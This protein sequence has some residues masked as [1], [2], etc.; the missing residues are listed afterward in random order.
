MSI[1][2]YRSLLQRINAVREDV[3][4]D[5]QTF[6]N[7]LQDALSIDSTQYKGGWNAASNTPN[8]SASSPASGDFYIVSKAGTT[9]LGGENKWLELDRVYY[10]GS[11]WQKLLSKSLPSGVTRYTYLSTNTSVTA[12]SDAGSS[13]PTGAS[14]G[15][16]YRNE[17]GRKV[18]WYLYGDTTQTEN[19]LGDFDGF[20]AVVDL[21][22]AQ[23]YLYWTLYTR[24]ELDGQDASWYRSRVT[25]NDEIAVQSASG[26]VLLHSAGMDV[27]TLHPDLPRVAVDIDAL[28]TNGLQG[29]TEVVWLMAL[30]T[31]S[32]YPEGYNEFVVEQAGFQFGENI[33]YCDLVAL[34]ESTTEY[35]DYYVGDFAGSSAFPSTGSVGQWLIETQEDK[36]FVWD[37]E[38]SDWVVT[39]AAAGPS[40]EGSPYTYVYDSIDGSGYGFVDATGFSNLPTGELQAESNAIGGSCT[41]NRVKIG[42]LV[43]V[44]DSV[45]LE[46]INWT[47]SP[48]YYRN[49]FCYIAKDHDVVWYQGYRDI[50]S[51]QGYYTESS[52]DPFAFGHNCMVKPYIGTSSYAGGMV[53]VGSSHAYPNSLNNFTLE[54]RL[55]ADFK[56]EMLVDGT[57][58]SRSE[59]SLS[60]NFVGGLDIWILAKKTQVYP[61]PTGVAPAIYSPTIPA[62]YYM[63]TVDPGGS[64]T[65]LVES[66]GGFYLYRHTAALDV[67]DV[68]LTDAEAAQARSCRIFRS[69][70]GASLE[71]RIS[72]TRGVA[73][74]DTEL[75]EGLVRDAKAY[76]HSFS[77]NTT[78]IS[79]LM[80]KYQSV[81]AAMGSGSVEVSLG[82]LQAMRATETDTDEQEL[83]DYVISGLAAQLAKFPR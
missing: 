49:A 56:L 42:T 57:V 62:N 4:V 45:V 38:G 29:D 43:N 79:A 39:G 21:R 66:G 25:Y 61:Q 11:Q 59:L 46:G 24:P 3:S 1:Y 48:L 65:E 26:R 52:S 14:A 5:L 69:Y 80:A 60:G 50:G 20:F 71:D 6:D 17:A 30:S 47:S 35:T 44:G 33:T 13:D 16:Y 64:E 82:L 67:T 55:N 81:L 27:S 34:P 22:G 73:D 9:S 75:L 7:D 36:T 76:F 28:T 12:G 63:A 32:N 53:N 78:E 77:Y 72:Y 19:T 18:N 40:P 70:S 10:N 54:W 41:N 74:A 15:W 68:P 23:S 58:Q 8:I 31:S 51:G 83:Q 2:S 37:E